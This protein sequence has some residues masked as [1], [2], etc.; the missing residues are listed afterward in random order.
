[1]STHRAVKK[2]VFAYLPESLVRYIDVIQQERDL[3]SRSATIQALLEDMKS[4]REPRLK[5]F[6]Q[7]E[8]GKYGNSVASPI[9]TVRDILKDKMRGI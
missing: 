9:E 5:E 7:I 8:A 6:L 2:N 3:K 4:L 1:M